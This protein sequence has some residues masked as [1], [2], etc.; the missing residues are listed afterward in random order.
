LP[1]KC[2]LQRY[3]EGG[4]DRVTDI[5]GTPFYMSPECVKGGAALT[6]GCQF[7]HMEHCHQLMLIP[8]VVTLSWVSDWSHGLAAILAVINWCFD[9]KI[10]W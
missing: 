5:A 7:G 8:R 3:T 9:C 10:T 2:D 1:F 6:P 4:D